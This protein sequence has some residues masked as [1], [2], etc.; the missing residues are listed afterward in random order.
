MHKLKHNYQQP[1]VRVVDFMVE[2]G[3][4]GSYT[5][6][7][8]VTDENGMMENMNYDEGNTTLGW[9]WDIAQ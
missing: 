9:Q 5:L 2:G 3:F 4:E 7:Q 8:P 1:T 6:N